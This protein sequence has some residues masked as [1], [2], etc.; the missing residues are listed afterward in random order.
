MLNRTLQGTVADA[1]LGGVK[2]VPTAGRFQS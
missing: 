2:P 1:L